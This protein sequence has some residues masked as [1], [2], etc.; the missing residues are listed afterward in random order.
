MTKWKVV[1]WWIASIVVGAMAL[2]FMTIELIFKWAS[3]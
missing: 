2:F 1:F 3:L